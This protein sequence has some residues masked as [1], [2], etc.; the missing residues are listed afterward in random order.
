MGKFRIGNVSKAW[1]FFKIL[2]IFFIFSTLI[3]LLVTGVNLWNENHEIEPILE[4]M[5]QVFNPLYTLSENSQKFIESGFFE[6]TGHFFQDIWNFFKNIYSFAEPIIIIYLW[7]YYLNL[8]STH[9]IIGDTSRK[10]NSIISTLIIFFFIQL[11]YV[12]TLTD[13]PLKTPFVAIGDIVRIIV[14][15]FS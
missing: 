11:L 1:G 5:G 8:F 4:E 15:L 2:R 14:N 3:S 13:L 10:A 6:R 9:V 7:L 12:G